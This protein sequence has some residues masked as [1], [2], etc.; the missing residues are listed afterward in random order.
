V[1]A[2]H[3]AVFPGY[4]MDLTTPSVPEKSWRSY[5][6]VHRATFDRWREAAIRHENEYRRRDIQPAGKGAGVK[7]TAR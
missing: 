7:L 6:R 4:A 3:K 2:L 5:Y 1:K